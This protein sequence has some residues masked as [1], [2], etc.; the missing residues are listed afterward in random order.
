MAVS[1]S[2]DGY[3]L[4]STLVS[5]LCLVLCCRSRRRRVRAGVTMVIRGAIRRPSCCSLI[6][7]AVRACEL[8]R[9]SSEVFA[10][11]RP[12]AHL[13]RP[14]QVLLQG[15]C[16]ASA[17][18]H[19]ATLTCTFRSRPS[20]SPQP[21]RSVAPTRRPPTMSASDEVVCVQ[22]VCL[23]MP[24]TAGRAVQ[25]IAA[26]AQEDAACFCNVMDCLSRPCARRAKQVLPL[27]VL[28]H[29]VP[30]ARCACLSGGC[31]MH[32]VFSDV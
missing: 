18:A 15:S 20:I 17:G 9:R 14:N 24:S 4:V 32:D 16:A 19:T 11:C 12:T 1:K 8:G 28:H 5:V 27:S 6:N 13:I 22:S 26:V 21:H 31:A 10:V 7:S 30:A 29:A 3:R 23:S 25:A 2:D